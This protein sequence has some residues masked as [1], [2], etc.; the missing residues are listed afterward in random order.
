[1]NAFYVLRKANGDI[2]TVDIKG[3]T[4]I[5]V[6]DHERGVRRSKG[7]NPELLVYVPAQAD[8]RLIERKFPKLDVP[9]FLV[10]S[11]DLDLHTGSEINQAEVFG[12]LELAQ[13]A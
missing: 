2:L 11:R 3:K 12:E 4:Y 7:A 9:F 10:E 1:M 8:R 5:P 6:W 13:A